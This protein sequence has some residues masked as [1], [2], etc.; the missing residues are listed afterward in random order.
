MKAEGEAGGHWLRHLDH[1]MQLA[2][3]R[4]SEL[5]QGGEEGPPAA[6]VLR[7]GRLDVWGY[8]S[9]AKDLK[10]PSGCLGITVSGAGDRGSG[11][12]RAGREILCTSRHSIRRHSSPDAGR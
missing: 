8:G 3:R 4:G 5:A 12:S 11:T 2:G 1:G 10:A 9:K 6:E 7:S